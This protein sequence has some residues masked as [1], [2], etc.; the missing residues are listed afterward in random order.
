MTARKI[1]SGEYQIGIWNITDRGSYWLAV[2]TGPGTLGDGSPHRYPTLFAAHESLT[3][4]PLT[5]Q[6]QGYRTIRERRRSRSL[7]AALR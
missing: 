2:A 6:P 4:E 5:Y 3:G 7:A 1:D